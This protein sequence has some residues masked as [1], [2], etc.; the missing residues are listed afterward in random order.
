MR[1]ILELSDALSLIATRAKRAVIDV[2]S[3][4]PL[5]DVD[6]TDLHDDC[7]LG[8]VAVGGTECLLNQLT[9]SVLEGGAERILGVHRGYP[10]PTVG[11]AVTAPI[12]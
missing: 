12:V 11:S 3:P 1:P 2:E 5:V 10:G 8:D 4:H 7:C 6:A 9:L